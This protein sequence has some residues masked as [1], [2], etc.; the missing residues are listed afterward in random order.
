[1]HTFVLITLLV[2]VTLNCA[3]D[4]IFLGLLLSGLYNIIMFL[5]KSLDI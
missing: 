4:S 1:M 2:V 3:L 5:Y